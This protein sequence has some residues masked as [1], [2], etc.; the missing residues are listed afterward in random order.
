MSFFSEKKFCLPIFNSY[1]F[2]RIKIVPAYAH[3][4]SKPLFL[5]KRRIE[6]LTKA[7]NEGQ[8]FLSFC[9]KIVFCF[10]AI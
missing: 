10:T 1:L 4:S 2:N 8:C 6:Y 5:I 7:L 9:L 3:V